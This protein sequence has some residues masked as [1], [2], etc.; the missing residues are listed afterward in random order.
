MDFSNYPMAYSNEF[1]FTPE[2]V[3]D[4]MVGFCAGLVFATRVFDCILGGERK[5]YKKF[6]Q[7]YESLVESRDALL[8]EKE[9]QVTKNEKDV[10]DYNVLVDR[11]NA[12][13]KENEDLQKKN[14]K[15]V[16]DY[17][18]LSEELDELRRRNEKDIDDYNVLA[19]M[20]NSLLEEKDAV[21]KRVSR[22]ESRVSRSLNYKE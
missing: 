3:A 20:Y 12:L 19:E 16:D 22:L 5:N 4:M 9:M 14:S 6:K 7:E 8:D 2:V 15:D 18:S 13:L 10:S 1:K 11:Y 21:D 17:N